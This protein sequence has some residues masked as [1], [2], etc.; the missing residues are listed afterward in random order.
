VI[1]IVQNIS[2][3]SINRI[4]E[5]GSRMAIPVDPAFLIYSNFEHVYGRA[6][7]YGTQGIAINQLRL[8]NALLGQ[9]VNSRSEAAAVALTAI[10]RGEMSAAQ[11]ELLVET[12]RSEILQT[13]EASAAMPYISSPQVTSGLALNMVA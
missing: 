7:P 1:H 6:A 4:A 11:T 5:S 9:L 12:L 8:L 13:R 10:D 3:P 2:I